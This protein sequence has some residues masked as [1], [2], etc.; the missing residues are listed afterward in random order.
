MAVVLKLNHG[1]ELRFYRQA[2]LHETRT[3]YVRRESR[4]LEYVA[5]GVG[6]RVTRV[7]RVR[8]LARPNPDI[9]RALMGAD[10]PGPVRIFDGGVEYQVNGVEHFGPRNRVRLSCQAFPPSQQR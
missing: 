9:E 7:E 5:G 3:I 10:T 8:Y 2:G 4:Q 6:G 1:V